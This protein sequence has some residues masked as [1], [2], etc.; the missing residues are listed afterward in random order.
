MSRSDFWP[1]AITLIVAGVS[2][3]V[4][5]QKSAYACIAVGAVI[6]LA[7]LLT[8]KKSDAASVGMSNPQVATQGGGQQQQVQEVHGDVHTTINYGPV[9]YN[10]ETTSEMKGLDDDGNN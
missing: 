1:V 4:G 6:V 9:F 3:F 2:Y 5:G 10:T 7:L 8:P